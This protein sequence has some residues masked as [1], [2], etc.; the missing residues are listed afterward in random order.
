MI[1]ELEPEPNSGSFFII[2]TIIRKETNMKE[3]KEI[4]ILDIILTMLIIVIPPL[5]IGALIA[6][7]F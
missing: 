1:I 4:S 5:L 3:T 2:I 6:T 7:L